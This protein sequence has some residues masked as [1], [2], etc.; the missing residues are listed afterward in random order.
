MQVDLYEKCE[1]ILSDLTQLVPSMELPHDTTTLAGRRKDFMGS[2]SSAFSRDGG[3]SEQQ[4]TF[5]N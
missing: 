4:E 2:A 3:F 5:S 1:Y